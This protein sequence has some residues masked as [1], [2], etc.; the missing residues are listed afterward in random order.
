MDGGILDNKPF[1]AAL[2]AISKLPAEGNTRRVL[3]Y[4]VPD[5]AAAAERRDPLPDGTLERP[6]LAQAAW[7]SLVSIPASQSIASHMTELRAHNDG[8]ATRWRRVVGAVVHMQTK[9]LLAG[10]AASLEAYR[11]RRVDGMIDYFLEETERRLAS[12]DGSAAVTAPPS[13]TGPASR[14]AAS[15]SRESATPTLG[16]RRATRQ[17]L[18]SVWRLTAQGAV[19][20]QTRFWGPFADALRGGLDPT[21][22]LTLQW[23]SRLPPNF[24]PTQPLMAHRWSWGLYALQFVSE[25]STEVLRRTQR[26]HALIP[27]W[28]Q[29]ERAIVEGPS[30]GW[31]VGDE[32]RFD[33]DLAMDR[34]RSVARAVLQEFGTRLGET[35]LKKQWSAAYEVA[36]LIQEGRR[37]ATL[38]V[39]NIGVTGF[40]NLVNEWNAQGGEQPPK[41]EALR[42]LEDLL[43]VGQELD[44]KN[45]VIASRLFNLLL[46][47]KRPI[48]LIIEAH[49]RRVVGRTDIDEAVAELRAVYRYL[50]RPA[51]EGADSEP[52]IHEAMLDRIAW[53][54]LALEVF[55]VTAGSRRLTP[56]AQAEIVQ[57]SARVK[58]AFGGSADP[59]K[60][61]AGMQLAH[62]GAFYKRSW[63]ANDWTFGC[64]DGIDRAV[65]IALNP[66]ALQKRYCNRQVLPKG[67][68]VPLSASKY[69]EHYL[70]NLAVAGAEPGIA[71]Y[72][73]E[74]WAADLPEIRDELAWLDLPATVP[75]PVLEH[76]AQALTRRLQME[77]LRRE[78]PEIAK[79]LMIERATGTPPSNE[80]GEPLLVRVAPLGVA[81][82]PDP[83]TAAQL[84]RDNLLGS[85]TLDMQVGTDRADPN[86]KPGFGDR[87]HRLVV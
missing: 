73:E 17:W 3:A 48:E 2:E 49:A 5:P 26:L 53:R 62:F 37:A 51:E 64:L 6:T 10:A 83:Q 45:E 14:S 8:A 84:A 80:A 85:E 7:R 31:A 68:T 74:L 47:L 22:R 60:K 81:A 1:D 58:S 12:A 55:E 65:R 30:S 46:D 59:A 34:G 35:P 33:D 75:P 19:M 41:I 42:L 44:E 13:P 29:E 52:P 57:I 36:A 40:T 11:S 39:G 82:V 71:P 4:I 56:G 67:E 86:G 77:T 76:C 25:F 23:A 24:E 79:S 50:Y 18:A 27:R 72:L 20:D 66:D 21:M 69:V 15:P 38:A 70:F 32:G 9:A 61:L 43:S 63:R 87:A 54:A 16:M 78:L 28:R